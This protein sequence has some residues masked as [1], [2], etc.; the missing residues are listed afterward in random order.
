MNL[1]SLRNKHIIFEGPDGAGKSTLIKYIGEQLSLAG[2]EHRVHSEPMH[3]WIREELPRHKM[4]AH[5]P[6]LLEK[7]E[8]S[9]TESN[10]YVAASLCSGFTVLQDRSWISSVVYQSD[11][12]FDVIRKFRLWGK[13]VEPDLYVFLM[14]RPEKCMQDAGE[15]HEHINFGL[16]YS[17]YDVVISQMMHSCKYDSHFEVFPEGTRSDLSLEVIASRLSKK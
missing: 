7:F 15:G 2:I 9:R 14:K 10:M 3:E 11:G 16:A 12:L 1:E 6:G 17:N 4:P 5:N 8:A 13:R